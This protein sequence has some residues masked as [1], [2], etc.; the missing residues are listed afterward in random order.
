[1]EKLQ[2][3]AGIL[4]QIL[5]D[6]A[7]RSELEEF[8][9]SVI[10]DELTRADSMDCDLIDECINC[11]EEL[12]ECSESAHLVLMLSDEKF[13]KKIAKK[14][15]LYKGRYKKIAAVC[16]AAAL[17]VAAGSAKTPQGVTV[18]RAISQ[19]VSSV[20][21]H[22][23]MGGIQTP[24]HTENTSAAE[25]NETESTAVSTTED[26][27]IPKVLLEKIY[28]V[29]P[30][31]LKTEYTLGESLNLRGVGVIAVYSDGREE[32]IPLESCD[33]TVSRGFY[34]DPGDYA[35]TVRY[36]EKTFSYKVTVYAE[37]KSVILNSVYGTFSDDFDFTVQSFDDVDLGGM[38]VIG[39]YSDGSEEVIP[40]SDC[41]ITIEPRFMD[42]ENKALVTVTYEERA[43]S[44]V[45]TQEVK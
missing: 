2:M 33:V 16:A 15:A 20:I 34:K 31:D 7:T 37:K 8:L 23:V 18:G 28:G 42:I 17:L 39:V 44:F 13:L 30:R 5:D 3:N 32:K 21:S 6:R 1:M 24:P 14:S 4:R 27:N 41:E 36:G 22:G 40:Q 11:L 26:V 29:F 19:K 43:F 9:N 25:N 35:V 38:T 10:D 45:L 12:S